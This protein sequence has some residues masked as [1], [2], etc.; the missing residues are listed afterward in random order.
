M[1]FWVFGFG[2]LRTSWEDVHGPDTTTRCNA[3]GQ[4]LDTLVTKSQEIIIGVF[5]L[6][7]IYNRERQASAVESNVVYVFRRVFKH[8]AEEELCSALHQR[9]IAVH[10]LLSEGRLE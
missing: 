2:M 6:I 5:H 1:R 8:L 7:T 10:L 9:M 4:D 3:V